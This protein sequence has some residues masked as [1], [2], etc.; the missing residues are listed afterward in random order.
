[1]PTH[2]VL[3]E[4]TPSPTVD[5]TTYALVLVE[6]PITSPTSGL[7]PITDD[8]KGSTAAT[9]EETNNPTMKPS[10]VTPSEVDGIAVNT[11]SSSTMVGTSKLVLVGGFT[12][13]WFYV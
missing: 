5:N 10:E 4:D 2:T 9:P 11:L 7:T 13:F 6:G 3:L 12:Y 1:L 8:T